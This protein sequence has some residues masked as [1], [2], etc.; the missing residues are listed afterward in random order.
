[1]KRVL[2]LLTAV[3]LVTPSILLAQGNVK[4]SLY[5]DPGY[6]WDNYGTPTLLINTPLVFNIMFENTTD[7]PVDGFSFNFVIRGNGELSR[8]IWVNANDN[9]LPPAYEPSIVQPDWSG[10]WVIHEINTFGWDGMLPDT[11]SVLAASTSEIDIPMPPG[12]EMT[13]FYELHMA[14][15]D[16]TSAYHKEQICFERTSHYGDYDWLFPVPVVFAGPECWDAAMCSCALVEFT[17]PFDTLIYDGQPFDRAY[18]YRQEDGFPPSLLFVDKGTVSNNWPTGDHTGEIQWHY[19]PVLPVCGWPDNENE[20][21]I[22]PCGISGCGLDQHIVLIFPS[23]PP[24]IKK[25]CGAD[26]FVESE[27]EYNYPMKAIDPEGEGILNWY[28]SA[29]PEPEGTCQITP[30]GLFTFVPSVNDNGS[31]FDITVT[32]KDCGEILRNAR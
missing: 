31:L 29:D 3:V 28:L 26:I 20:V 14:L 19:D 27:T 7:T 18:E 4:C 16:T 25:A 12:M 1:M 11:F 2:I 32:A 22:H 30:D 10:D 17:E 24:A 8:V 13:T 9:P 15:F 23:E 5:V 21:I 6:M